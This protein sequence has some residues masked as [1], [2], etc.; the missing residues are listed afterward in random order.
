MLALVGGDRATLDQAGG[1]EAV[2]QARYIP[3]G[4]IEALGEI[5]LADAFLLRQCRQHV[6]LGHGKADLAQAFSDGS[7]HARLQPHQPEPHPE[8]VA[9][10]CLIGHSQRLFA[11]RIPCGPAARC[12]RPARRPAICKGALRAPW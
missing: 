12:Y 1:D 4:D 7:A 9:F 11:A 8:R 10:A 6:A 2:D 5:L 3:L